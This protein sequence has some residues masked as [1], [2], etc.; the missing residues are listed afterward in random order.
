MIVTLMFA[1]PTFAQINS[2]I[3]DLGSESYQTRKKATNKLSNI[4][5][6]DVDKLKKYTD[7][8]H[9]LERIL[10]INILV[11]RFNSNRYESFIKT[12]KYV[13]N[14][15][16]DFPP[17]DILWWNEQER[18]FC[19]SPD[20]HPLYYFIYLQCKPYFKDNLRLASRDLIV[21]LIANGISPELI[22]MMIDE[23]FRRE[24]TFK[25]RNHK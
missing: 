2:I 16:D 17:I 18:K 1:Q 8:E 24:E 7:E 12:Q 14:R 15:W 3:K 25:T 11:N 20:S 6:Y 4:N 22:Q 13:T 19:C 21:D 5:T 9:N 23:M 10:R